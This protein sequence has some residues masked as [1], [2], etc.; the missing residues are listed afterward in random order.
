MRYGLYFVLILYSVS[1]GQVY[2]SNT[3][4]QYTYS[5][6]GITDPVFSAAYDVLKARC[7]TCHPNHSG[8][9]AFTTVEQWTTTGRVIAGSAATSPIISR[10]KNYGGDMPTTAGPIPADELAAL[11]TWINSL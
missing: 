2:N 10:L 1:C 4:D 5:S 6:S 11:E 8:W 9:A 7:M 3:F